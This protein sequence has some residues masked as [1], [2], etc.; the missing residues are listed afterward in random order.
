MKEIVSSCW[1]DSTG[2]V[3]R[4]VEL[5][6]TF[7]FHKRLGI[8][9][10]AEWQPPKEKNICH[11]PSVSSRLHM[12]SAVQSTYYAHVIRQ[13][14]GLVTWYN[15]TLSVTLT[16]ISHLTSC[17]KGCSTDTSRTFFITRTVSGGLYQVSLWLAGSCIVLQIHNMLSGTPITCFK[18]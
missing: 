11:V 15:I 2:R 16:S 10:V 14:D 13:C 6:W 7:W 8:C 3:C 9:C 17:T 12:T 1:L 5:L 4:L 18:P